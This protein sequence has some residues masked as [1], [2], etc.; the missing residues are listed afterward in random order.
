MCVHSE[1]TRLAYI[2]YYNN[3]G[4]VRPMYHNAATPITIKLQ[5]TD[6]SLTFDGDLSANLTA[7]FVSFRATFEACSILL[8][9]P[10]TRKQTNNKVILSPL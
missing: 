3:L 2:E 8:P 7:T 1:T 6:S 4:Y 10:S 9:V 5:T